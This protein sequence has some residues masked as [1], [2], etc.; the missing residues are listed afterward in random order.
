MSPGPEKTGNGAYPALPTYHG[1]I[2]EHKEYWFA[3][4]APSHWPPDESLPGNV[5]FALRYRVPGAE[6]W[7]NNHG[8]EPFDSGRFGNPAGR[9]STRC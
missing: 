1:A 3:R 8:E 7:D 9:I 4:I 2:D 5:E 6:Y